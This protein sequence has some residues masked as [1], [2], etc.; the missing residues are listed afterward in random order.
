MLGVCYLLGYGCTQNIQYGRQL[1]ERSAQ[2]ACR[3]FGLGMMYAE[4]LGVSE[5]I[6]KG[7][8]YLKAAG[9]YPPAKEALTHYKK[10]LFGVWRRK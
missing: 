2:S 4:G 8:E 3:N 6:A 7:V 1:L 9:E 5:N 10:S